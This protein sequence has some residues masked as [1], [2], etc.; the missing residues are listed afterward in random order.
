MFT[1]AVKAP[2][3]QQDPTTSLNNNNTAKLSRHIT[4]KTLSS[5]N[6][7]QRSCTRRR[8]IEAQE[9]RCESKNCYHRFPSGPAATSAGTLL[10]E[11]D[12]LVLA[13]AKW[14]EA[15]M[16]RV[17]EGRRG[18]GTHMSVR[19]GGEN[20][21]V[22]LGL[23]SERSMSMRERGKGAK[24]N[25]VLVLEDGKEPGAVHSLQGGGHG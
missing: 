2:F 7:P 3:A 14:Q 25:L 8:K 12:I 23:R 9:S 21:D 1:P 5:S 13:H 11:Q 15:S 6:Q 17:L 22:V 16:A 24:F 20:H 18:V 4:W 19:P 10:L